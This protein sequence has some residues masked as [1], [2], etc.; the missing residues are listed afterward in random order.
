MRKE[1][2]QDARVASHIKS[3][4]DG[5]DHSLLTRSMDPGSNKQ[6]QSAGK[7]LSDNDLA[8]SAVASVN[9]AEDYIGVSPSD[10]AAFRSAHPLAAGFTTELRESNEYAERL[11]SAQGGVSAEAFPVSQRR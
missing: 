5:G 6:G 11:A 8:S 3:I 10:I 9:L 2:V 7:L 4:L 1:A